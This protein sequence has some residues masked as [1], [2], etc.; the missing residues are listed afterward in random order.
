MSKQFWQQVKWHWNIP[1]GDYW[2]V[3]KKQADQFSTFLVVLVAAN[4]VGWPATVLLG[5]Y[6]WTGNIVAAFTGWLVVQ[7][8]AGSL[9][10]SD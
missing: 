6:E 9:F 7:F 4:V 2:S 5:I 8:I 10:R 3:D 1:Y